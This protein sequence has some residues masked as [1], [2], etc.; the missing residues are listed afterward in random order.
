MQKCKQCEWEFPDDIRICPYCGH[1]VE[2][3]DQKQKRRFNLRQSPNLPGGVKQVLPSLRP[4]QPPPITPS[5]KYIPLAILVSVVIVALVLSGVLLV[6]AN[7]A[8]QSLTASPSLLDFGPVRVGSKSVLS[9]VIMKTSEF[10]LAW[11]IDPANVQWLQVALRPKAGQ[12]S[13]LREDIYNVTANT[14]KLNKGN[15]SA[16]LLFSSE[17][18]N[19]QQ[20][21]VKI[22][23][24]TINPPAKLI[25]SP[26]SLD[27]GSL[28]AG[29]QKTLLL[30]VS[31]SGGRELDWTAD[32]GKMLWLTLDRYSG[33]IAAGA[34]PQPINV[35]VNTATLTANHYTLTIN[36]SSNSGTVPVAVKLDVTTP[37]RGITV[38][39]SSTSP[40][41]IDVTPQSLTFIGAADQSDPPPQS[42]TISNCGTAMG[43][44]SAAPS[45]ADNTNWL[46]IS[47]NGGPLEGGATKTITITTS[48]LVAKLPAGT[49]TGQVTFTMGSSSMSVQ[50]MLTVHSICFNANPQSTSLKPTLGPGYASLLSVMSPLHILGL[51][52]LTNCGDTAGNWA[53]TP[54]NGWLHIIPTQGQLKSGAFTQVSVS[55]DSSNLNPGTYTGTITFTLTTIAGQL[56]RTVQETLTVLPPTLIVTPINLMTGG[57]CSY[58]SVSNSD[59][60]TVTLTNSSADGLLDWS[61]S[62]TF[63]NVGFVPPSSPL[64][65]GASVQV[66]ISGLPA[67]NQPSGASGTV[68]FTGPANTVVLK[69]DC[70]PG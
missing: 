30:T 25:V 3:G 32:K 2:P 44:W 61:A 37:Q 6:R 36:F 64:P 23:V 1:P 59:S 28:K 19:T 13:N 27:F 18:G 51:V 66:T 8:D 20:V 53:G 58:D 42:V 50:V 46:Y 12:S 29:D 57:T 67:C 5:R 69:W 68:T 7:R 26:L 16:R 70:P 40:P 14:G 47:Q 22:Q 33:K 4:S 63:V 62:S 55:A 41:C 21:T 11:R 15:Y 65:P 38:T 56:S 52:W 24:V 31:N 10:P 35:M 54:G 43:T 45:T 9:V 34:I 17:R 49:Y 48:N 60:C 39:S